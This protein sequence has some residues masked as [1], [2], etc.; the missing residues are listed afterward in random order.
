M[1]NCAAAARMKQSTMQE[2]EGGFAMDRKNEDWEGEGRGEKTLSWY[3]YLS[4]RVPWCT[5]IPS[6][7]GE[8]NVDRIR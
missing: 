1:V 3:H 5:I 7:R 6:P 8:L 2:S 4:T